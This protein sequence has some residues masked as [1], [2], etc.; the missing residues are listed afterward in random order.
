MSFAPRQLI[1][2]AA[3]GIWSLR[4]GTYLATRAIK[5]GGDSRFDEI[6]KQPNRFTYYWFA[7]GEIYILLIFNDAEHTTA[8][9][10]FAVGL[11]VYLSNSAPPVVHPAL[12]IR[13][14]LSLGL[15]VTSFLIEVVADTQKSQWRARKDRKLHDE[16]F[17]SSGLWSLSRHPKYAADFHFQKA[18]H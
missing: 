13:D 1:L 11:P 14:Y 15:I 3:L 6:K 10:V 4:L 12:N 7:Q 9:W 5:A 18:M 8:T 16:K 17:I 2:S